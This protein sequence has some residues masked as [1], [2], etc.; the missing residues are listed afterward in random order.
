MESTARYVSV[1]VLL[2][3]QTLFFYT[4][5]TA[6]QNGSIEINNTDFLNFS[7]K[8]ISTTVPFPPWLRAITGLTEW[9]DANPPYISDG[10]NLTD[11]FDGPYYEQVNACD[12]AFMNC[13]FDCNNCVGP[14][15]ILQCKELVQTFDDGPSDATPRLLNFFNQIQKKVS[16]FVIGI[17]VLMFPD[18]FRQEHANGHFL[19]LHTYNHPYL[20]GL[21]NQQIAA[22]FQW[23]IWVMNATAGVVPRYFRPPYGGLDNRVRT[24]ASRYGLTPI[25]WQWDSNDWRTVNESRTAQDV[26]TDVTNWKQAG[27]TGII[28][29]H[30]FQGSLVDIGIRVS[31]ILGNVSTVVSANCKDPSA[32]WYR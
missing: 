21:T 7:L 12:N 8:A 13:V 15:D 27:D 9:P 31:S 23:T 17:Q 22:Q 2:I 24:I 3:L 18:I 26:Y 20:P 11:I 16:F 4:D 25:V 19:G 32:P 1:F 5:R 30:D 10:V 28:L 6:A 14:D 29:E